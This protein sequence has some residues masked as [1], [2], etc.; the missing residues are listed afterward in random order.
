MPS[1]AANGAGTN[2]GHPSESPSC[3]EGKTGVGPSCRGSVRSSLAFAVNIYRN[4][5]ENVN[6]VGRTNFRPATGWIRRPVGPL[7]PIPV[8][9]IVRGPGHRA[10][11]LTTKMPYQG[12]SPRKHG[13]RRFTRGS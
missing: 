5:L 12:V 2:E 8:H 10:G 7:T 4:E 9:G 1:A 13:P 3:G 11:A 6:E